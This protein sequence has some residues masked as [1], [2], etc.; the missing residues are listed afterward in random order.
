LQDVGPTVLA[1]LDVEKPAEM[2]G[3]DL[4]AGG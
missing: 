3:V 4:R 1:M 2:S